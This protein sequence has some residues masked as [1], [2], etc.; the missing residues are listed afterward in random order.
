MVGYLDGFIVA[1]TINV[2]GSNTG[3]Q[4]HGYHP[5]VQLQ[6]ANSAAA[7]QQCEAVAQTNT[8]DEITVMGCDCSGCCRSGPGPA[9][10][11]L[12]GAGPSKGPQLIQFSG[13]AAVNGVYVDLVARATNVYTSSLASRT[14]GC[15]SGA[16]GSIYVDVCARPYNKCPV[17]S[18]SC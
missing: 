14:N 7:V 16:F 17:E 10:N 18:I 8:C 5:N 12:G 15:G 3:T 13:A 11:N 9:Q 1:R 2:M 4:W 6:C